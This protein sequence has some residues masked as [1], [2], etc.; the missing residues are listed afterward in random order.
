MSYDKA[1]YNAQYNKENYIELR[2]RIAKEEK[3]AIDR[4]WQNKGYPSFAAYMK[5]LIKRDMTETPKNNNDNHF[6]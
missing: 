1:K 2:F 3:P 4:H 5:E 6:T